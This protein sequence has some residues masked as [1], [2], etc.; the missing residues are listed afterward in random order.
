MSSSTNT[1]ITSSRSS[2]ML[3][4]CIP[5]RAW[6]SSIV[7]QTDRTC[8]AYAYGGPMRYYHASVSLSAPKGKGGKDK[9]GASKGD[10]DEA[11]ADLPDLSGVRSM[12][13]WNPFCSVLMFLMCI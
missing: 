4:K 9:K 8:T 6:C 10:D 12:C 1:G 13:V 11:S 3:L 7:T 5:R 2:R